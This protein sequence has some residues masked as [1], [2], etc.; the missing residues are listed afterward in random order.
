LPAGGNAVMI[1]TKD[2]AKQQAAWEYIK[3]AT[4]PVGQTLMVKYTGYMPSNEIAIK[5]PQLLGKFYDENPNH[6]TSIKQLPVMTS[7]YAFPGENALKITDVIKD[8]LQT[9]VARKQ[10]PE[11]GVS[12][13]ARD[14][15][16]LLPK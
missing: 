8:H 9:V 14:V 4:G 7:W 10:A 5:D 15:Q 2:R 12:A 11:Q 6:V 16:T 1:F 13:M 3:F